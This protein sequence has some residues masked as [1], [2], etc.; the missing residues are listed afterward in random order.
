[1]NS[2]RVGILFVVLVFASFA[3]S[4]DGDADIAPPTFNAYSVFDVR[5][6]RTDRPGQFT[7]DTSVRQLEVL[8][9]LGFDNLRNLDMGQ[10]H[11]YNYS[12]CKV[13]KDGKYLVPDNIFVVPL[14]EGRYKFFADFYDHWD[15]YTSTTSSKVNL[16][17]SFFGN[18]LGLSGSFSREKQTVKTNQVNY[19][20]K[21]T[22]VTFRDRVYQ[23]HLDTSAELHP[24]FK[25]KIYE[26]AASV[27]NN[28]TEQADYL[29]ELLIRDYGT[30]YITSVEAGAVFA[31]VDSIST[32]YANNIEVTNITSAASFSFPLLQIFNVNSTFDFGFNY[33]YTQQN[34]E[35]YFTNQK[36]SEI[37]TI[38]GAP[39]SPH[40]DLE[41][42]LKDVP[43]RMATI[44]RTADPLHFAIVP[45]RFPELPIPT[46]RTIADLVL[47]ATDRYYR[48]NTKQGCVDPAAQN[49]DFQANFGDSSLCDTSFSF[50]DMAF[51]G[52]YQ[53]CS[54]RGRED[55]C[56][57]RML[58]QEN[59]LT[60]GLSCPAGYTPIPLLS[61]TDSYVGTYTSYY[62][63]CTLFFF[64]STES[65]TR[66]DI[67]YA[68]Y[69][70]FWCVAINPPR[71]YR[72]Y[73]F[74]G[75]FTPTNSNPVTGTQSCPP[76]FRKQKIAT[77][78][79]VCVSNDYE[80]GSAHS[81]SFAGFHSCTVGN[82]LAIPARNISSFPDRSDW[83]RNCPPGYSVHLVVVE[84]GCEI[85]VCI[86][87]GAFTQKY[88]L[89]PKLPPFHKQP[90]YIPYIT[91]QLTVIGS[92]GSIL[93]RN[94][95][96]QWKL[97]PQESKEVRA[98]VQKVSQNANETSIDPALMNNSPQ[99]QKK[100]AP[101]SAAIASIVLSTVT[102]ATLIVLAS[103]WMTA[104]VCKRKS[105]DKESYGMENK[106]T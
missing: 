102:L 87:S 14:Q 11:F 66:T 75:F 73:L 59:P 50:I 21:T 53:T 104:R 42:W 10:V 22:R 23:V 45:S 15:N 74:G 95:E 54:H 89:P 26:I 40:L 88:L 8:P 84:N 16:E 55:V 90:P 38:G 105:K 100:S 33:R 29:C 65:S 43:N 17:P 85:N 96:G 58:A 46:V 83:P 99:V 7:V 82:P 91:D 34:M 98:F 94:I 71:E 103:G 37:F 31:K 39:L 93:M 3:N 80:L 25:S 57:R 30:H 69:E 51:G 62:E 60:G 61:G 78:V 32:T 72:G 92:D 24:F 9:G 2:V 18:L 101:S 68:D 47:A 70:T 12:A 79:T 35:R 67:S 77:D 76:Y 4:Q 20:A 64:C 48:L 27:Q 63:T 19:D 44:D 1:M 97:Y 5:N 81:V 13:T 49:F 52:L 36:R 106:H 86:E 41:Q 28:D 56:S 6:C